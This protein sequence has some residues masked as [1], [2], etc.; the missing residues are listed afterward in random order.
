MA[1]HILRLRREGPAPTTALWVPGYD[2]R[3]GRRK[4]GVVSGLHEDLHVMRL[5]DGMEPGGSSVNE[6]DG[7]FSSHDAPV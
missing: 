1:G 3:R 6:T 7:D 5:T 4:H 2:R